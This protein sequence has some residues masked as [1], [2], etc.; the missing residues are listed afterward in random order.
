MIDGYQT[1]HPFRG[2]PDCFLP[3]LNAFFIY[4]L[5]HEGIDDLGIPSGLRHPVAAM[6]E[7]KK[8]EK[9]IILG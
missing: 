2:C 1:I 8:V 4:F 5:S 9:L 3:S 7:S 6:S